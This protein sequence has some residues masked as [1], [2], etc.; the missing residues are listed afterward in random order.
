MT[1]AAEHLLP[2][3]ECATCDH[4]FLRPETAQKPVSARVKELLKSNVP[5]LHEER[6]ELAG[7][8][9]QSSRAVADLEQRIVQAQQMLDALVR[10]RDIAAEHLKNAKTLL[11]PIRT[12]SDD[13]LREI[14]VHCGKEWD[15][16]YLA[17]PLHDS[18]KTTLPPWTISQVS[19]Q[20]RCVAISTSRL[21][22]SISLDF[23]SYTANHAVSLSFKLG[24][25][26]QRAP[27]C[28][29]ALRIHSTTD[30]SGHPIFPMLLMSMSRW[31]RL[32]IDV[33]CETLHS[34][35]AYAG[36]L[37]SLTTLIIKDTPG[38]TE[39]LSPIST[40]HLAS[41]L[42]TLDVDPRVL[43]HLHLTWKQLTHLS[44][45][46]AHS[47]RSLEILKKVQGVDASI[48]HLSF[49]FSNSKIPP[50]PLNESDPPV[51]L[52]N[53]VYIAAGE[54]ASAST[55]IA[56]LFMNINTPNL[57]Q[58]FLDY[59]HSGPVEF[60][61]IPLDNRITY[62]T[63]YCNLAAQTRTTKRLIDFISAGQSLDTLVLHARGIGKALI[64][65][66]A[67]ESNR[68]NILPCLTILDLRQSTY[69]GVAH[70]LIVNMIASRRKR[71]K[72]DESLLWQLHLD[73]P[74]V[75]DDPQV[76][77]QWKNLCEEGLD[78]EYGS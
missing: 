7:I 34:L 25:C 46:G 63:L 12:L 52:P 60:P 44:S 6:L 4:I 1:A 39:H 49:K 22:S 50:F 78:V 53:V 21:W 73:S 35:S 38:A 64:S 31:K 45:W 24:L 70:S 56:R 62:L 75:L 71:Q 47:R 5:P 30:L 16:F 15:D 77:A 59:D 40:F 43:V 76:A 2:T 13:I 23:P 65:K 58:I 61:A 11:H 26:L 67:R 33:P 29:L 17:H 74:L 9:A 66:L 51:L 72:E 42:K 10:E 68:K 18:I 48:K 19:R 41:S 55:S 57:D 14:F 20:W 32:R 3:F 27:K 36:F 69:D 28:D 8:A 54:T 37:V